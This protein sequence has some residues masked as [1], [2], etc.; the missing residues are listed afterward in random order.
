[1]VTMRIGVLD[2][3]GSVEEHMQHLQQF[4]DV[5]P[6]RAKTPEEISSLDG[7]IIPGGE[8]TAIA[9]MLKAFQLTDLLKERILSGMPVYG[10][11]AGMILLADSIEDETSH[12]GVMDIQVKRNAY[13]SQMDSFIAEMPLPPICDRPLP[14]VFIRAPYI[15]SHGESVQILTMVERKAVAARQD[16]MLVT[17][18]HPELTEHTEVHGYFCQM[19]RESM[20]LH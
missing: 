20:N 12:L 4:P 2:I 14:L 18:F 8:S 16:N 7:L 15:V 5:E 10:T 3:Q 9:K 19:V 6:I 1:M 17:S 11:C 13:G